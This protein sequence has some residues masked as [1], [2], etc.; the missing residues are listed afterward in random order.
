[1][2][3]CALPGQSPC[4]GPTVVDQADR[5]A[6]PTTYGKPG[7]GAGEALV[8]VDSAPDRLLTAFA[9]SAQGGPLRTGP[10][11]DALGN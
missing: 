1:M 5:L 10:T 3:G 7:L 6:R 11:A 9:V 8:P 4:P 2:G